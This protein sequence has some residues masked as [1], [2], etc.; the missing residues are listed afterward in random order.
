MMIQIKLNDAYY[1]DMVLENS[2]LIMMTK[3]QSCSHYGDDVA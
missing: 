1:V 3:Y 2:I